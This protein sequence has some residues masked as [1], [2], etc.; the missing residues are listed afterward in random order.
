MIGGI[1]DFLL[2]TVFAG[3]VIAVILW[4]QEGVR[5]R[6]LRAALSKVANLVL[7]ALP[8]RI[9]FK[10]VPAYSWSNPSQYDESK[11]ALELLGFHRGSTF[12]A[13]PQKWVSEFWINNEQ[14]LFAMIVDSPKRGI[15]C[16][17]IARYSD[18]STH[19]FENT[20]DCGL[21]H[22]E[23]HNC[24]HCGSMTPNGLV[25]RA[26]RDQQRNRVKVLDIVDCVSV[27]EHAVNERLA[28]RRNIGF[29][30]EEAQQMLNSLRGTLSTKR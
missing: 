5:K 19:C 11:A 6:R 26:M 15:H 2:P 22:F 14:G 28:W 30:S 8:Q 25:E 27:Y 29:T 7:A 17:V 12:V 20:D 10:E 24:H 23:R 16:E 3:V 21:R 13:S 1:K 18:G 9:S 4:I